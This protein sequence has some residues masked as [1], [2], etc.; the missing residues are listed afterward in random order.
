MKI[1][2][3]MRWICAGFRWI[4]DRG[5][6]NMRRSWIG[7]TVV[8]L[9]VVLSISFS[10]GAFPWHKKRKALKIYGF[11]WQNDERPAVGVQVGLFDAG[12]GKLLAVTKS[13]F[14]GKY[15][16]KNLQPGFYVVRTGKFSRTVLL[17]KRD[18]NVHFDFSSPNGQKD[19]VAMAAKDLNKQLNGDAGP[20]DPALTKW[21]AGNYYSY[22]GSTERRLMLC[23]NGVF[24]DSHESSFSGNSSDSLGNQTSAFGTANQ[25][26]G[27]GRWAIQ[28]NRQQGTITFGYKGKQARKVQYHAIGD[29]CFIIGGV[30]YCYKGP[31]RC[32]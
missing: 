18:A 22:S 2:E 21:I 20:T 5:G 31:P 23:P 6:R 10:A 1:I 32:N 30:K 24:Y 17:Q 29:N 27:S 14:F 19:F 25:G 9:A 26:Q 16:F 11:L 3:S 12:S 7:L 4:P 13:N 15:K 28:G 8:V